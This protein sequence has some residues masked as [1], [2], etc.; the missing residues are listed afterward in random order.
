MDFHN[1]IDALGGGAVRSLAGFDR[2]AAL[3]A[4]FNPSRV[5]TWAKLHAVYFGRTRFKAQQRAALKL[6][7]RF[8]LDQLAYVET[9]LKALG[10]SVDAPT[11]WRLRQD[12]L[13]VPGTFASL[14]RRAN[15][16]LPKPVP[17]P[18]R[19]RLEITKSIFGMRAITIVA[20]E[21]RIADLE[22]ALRQN[23]DSLSPE[24]LQMLENFF[25]LINDAQSG[26]AV[27]APSVPRP[28]VSIGLDAAVRILNNDGDDTLFQLS[29]GTTITGAELLPHIL[30][31]SLEVAI[32]HPQEGP[33][34]LYRGS[35][36][37]NEKQR[38]LAALTSPACLFPGCR[39]GAIHCET[40]H[41]TAWKRGGE[42][43]MA[44]LAP[45]CR[46]H[47]R[48]N[49]DDPGTTSRGRITVRDGRPIWVSPNGFTAE[50]PPNR[51]GAMH[52]L[53]GL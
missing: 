34:N 21:R 38:T 27:V 28:V 53:F 20:D 49:D 45:L 35:R 36:F 22:Y 44:N 1:L 17:K 12:L 13:R 10:D 42:T 26:E 40:H 23:L 37:A 18:P 32:F 11:R 39:H 46:Y 25:T 7:D 8:A 52:Q 50:N 41:V 4:G 2:N 47:N 5:R 24:S 14:R 48:V 51:H 29:D 43:N 33:V 15:E 3:A 6:A 31:E 30:G 19:A 9:R 16:V